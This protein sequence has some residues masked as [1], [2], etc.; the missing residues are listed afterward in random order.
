MARLLTLLG[1]A[2]AICLLL[3]A[4]LALPAEPTG[5]HTTLNILN[6]SYHLRSSHV[7]QHRI[8]GGHAVGLG[9]LPV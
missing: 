2:L 5:K 3:G 6:D 8:E 9:A 1:L 4:S 7:L